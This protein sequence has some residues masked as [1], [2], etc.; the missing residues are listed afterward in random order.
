[1]AWEAQP[2]QLVLRYNNVLH[3]TKV[4]FQILLQLYAE[5]PVYSALTP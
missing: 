3:T 2:L 1:M 4:L 5:W